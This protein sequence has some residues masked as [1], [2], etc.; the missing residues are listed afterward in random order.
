MVSR[1]LLSAIGITVWTAVLVTAAPRVISH[2]YSNEHNVRIAK[3]HEE[4][5]AAGCNDL[6]I[7]FDG[8]EGV[9]QSEEKSI[10]KSEA[11]TLRVDGEHNGGVQVE[12]SDQ[13]SD[14]VTLCKAARPGAD[15][16]SV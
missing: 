7:E 13:A 11:P 2:R 8:R 16:A 4:W 10:S 1:T 14:S 15:A 3:S 6:H 12:G 9:M 5:P